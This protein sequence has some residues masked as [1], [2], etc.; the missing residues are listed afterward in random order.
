MTRETND[1]SDYGGVRLTADGDAFVTTRR[2]TEN[3]IWMGDASGRR[4]A[5]LDTSAARPVASANQG[6][7]ISWAG[8]RLLYASQSGGRNGIWGIR[9]GQAPEELVPMAISPSATADG[10]AIVYVSTDNSLWRADA[11]GRGGTRLVVDANLPVITPDGRQVLFVSSSRSKAVVT[12]WSQAI[13]GGDPRQV[14]DIAALNPDVSRDGQSL[15]FVNPGGAQGIVVCE[16]PG[17]RSRRRFTPPGLPVGSTIRWT[18]DG[19]GVAYVNA[20]AGP[21]IWIQPLD[22]SAPRPFTRFTDGRTIG[23]FA[24]SADGARLAIVRGK[25]RTDIVLFRGIHGQRD[26]PGPGR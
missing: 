23:S 16:L 25:T 21:N 11:D 26:S 17:C 9:S 18:P 24:W 20:E 22:G 15:A 12:L 1:V 2:D 3:D 19:K 8:D 4:G 14:V 13:E 5:D 7:Q 10:G 6:G